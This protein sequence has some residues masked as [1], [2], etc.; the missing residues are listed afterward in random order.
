MA[1]QK[2]TA[3]LQTTSS[4]LPASA[5]FVLKA[6]DF[7]STSTTASFIA[8]KSEELTQRP[9]TKGLSDYLRSFLPGLQDVLREITSYLPTDQDGAQE[10]RDFEFG[11]RSKDNYQ[12]TGMAQQSSYQNL[13]RY[14][15]KEKGLSEVNAKKVLWLIGQNNGQDYKVGSGFIF[16]L[17]SYLKNILV[18]GRLQWSEK[19]EKAPPEPRSKRYF[20]IENLSNGKIK[21]IATDEFYFDLTAE[22]D[23][24]PRTPLVATQKIEII[25]DPTTNPNQVTFNNIT[26][27]FHGEKDFVDFFQEIINT[28]YKPIIEAV[29]CDQLAQKIG[30]SAKAKKEADIATL[31]LL[32]L[33]KNKILALSLLS[34]I[35]PNINSDLIWEKLSQLSQTTILQLLNSLLLLPFKGK[36]RFEEKKRMFLSFTK[37]AE[38]DLSVNSQTTPDLIGA[39]NNLKLIVGK[40]ENLEPLIFSILRQIL[41]NERNT[42]LKNNNFVSPYPK[43]LTDQWLKN[44]WSRL[45]PISNITISEIRKKIKSL[46]GAK[47]QLLKVRVDQSLLNSSKFEN[48]NTT[49]KAFYPPPKNPT[50]FTLSLEV[51]KHINLISGIK[52]DVTLVPNFNAGFAIDGQRISMRFQDKNG[53]AKTLNINTYREFASDCGLTEEEAKYCFW[54]FLQDDKTNTEAGTQV[55]GC[56][57]Y[58][59]IGSFF[60]LLIPALNAAAFAKGH[61]TPAF[62]SSDYAFSGK[63]KKNVSG[64]IELELKMTHPQL[65]YCAWKVDYKHS[66]N[67]SERQLFLHDLQLCIEKPE[68]LPE[69]I[70]TLLS[71]AVAQIM[72][73][74][75]AAYGEKKGDTIVVN[76][77]SYRKFLKVNRKEIENNIKKSDLPFPKKIDAIRVLFKETSDSRETEAIKQKSFRFTIPREVLN[78]SPKTVSDAASNLSASRGL[79]CIDELCQTINNCKSAMKEEQDFNLSQTDLGPRIRS[80]QLKDLPSPTNQQNLVNQIVGKL[81]SS[82]IN[83]PSAVEWQWARKI[84]WLISQGSGDGASKTGNGLFYHLDKMPTLLLAEI[85]LSSTT[86]RIFEIVRDQKNKNKVKISSTLQCIGKD[87]EKTDFCPVICE[88]TSSVELDFAK[89]GEIEIELSDYQ[90]DFY[91]EPEKIETLKTAVRDNYYARK[92]NLESPPDQERCEKLGV[93]IPAINEE[94]TQIEKN[95]VLLNMLGTSTSSTDSNSSLM[96]LLFLI[97]ILKDSLTS[98]TATPG[99][100][101]FF[102]STTKPSTIEAEKQMAPAS[103]S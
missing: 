103:T 93:D 89:P 101:D 13:V 39:L 6:E 30:L 52:Y 14:L 38:G 61:Y 41:E 55:N 42:E 15:T 86:N 94:A 16:S 48:I 97:L 9:G 19:Y 95:K 3:R 63:V 81:D 7:P 92:T 90:I 36:P 88:A 51:F 87:V 20:T 85:P 1:D 32:T 2:T 35:A 91:G 96:L 47:T 53:I 23:K 80:F 82:K 37:A 24:S 17:R 40:N 76:Q 68:S 4:N 26:A 64:I 46:T 43:E 100:Q 45:V 49:L 84:I 60:S 28:V 8:E 22:E 99:K 57:I 72:Y 66:T 77:E 50:S 65:G 34:K 67:A 31:L 71:D 79:K 33:K 29:A 12:L 59:A 69:D 74:A 56:S 73:P 78:N 21:I 98:Q 83:D 44:L 11:G 54:L 70:S 58:P 62:S 75:F 5:S 27:E 10:K 102:P 25:F 18:L